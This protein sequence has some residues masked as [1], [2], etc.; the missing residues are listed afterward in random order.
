MAQSVQDLVRTHFEQASALH[1]RIAEE[2][3]LQ[4]TT[5]GRALAA[6]LAAGNKILIAGNGG[7][8]ADAQHF[9]AELTGRYIHDRRALAGLAL[10]VDCSALTA[11]GNDYGFDAVFARQIEALAQPGDAFIGISTSGRSP[12]ILRAIDA[13]HKAHCAQIILMTG[14]DGGA[15]ITDDHPRPPHHNLIIPSHITAHIQEAHT[16]VLH[17][18]CLLIERE[19]NLND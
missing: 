7:S 18:W 19:L 3:S 14:G 5:I 16:A 1:A 11:I 13:A 4:I 9:A 10:S 12:N 15:Y 17:T 2:L 6:V 8:A